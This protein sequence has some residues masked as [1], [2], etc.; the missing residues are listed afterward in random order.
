MIFNSPKNTLEISEINNLENDNLVTID[1]SEESVV[2]IV[3]IKTYKTTE[4]K[5][6]VISGDIDDI[7]NII[8]TKN[9]GYHLKFKGNENVLLFGDVDKIPDTQP[10]IIENILIALGKFYSIKPDDISLTLSKKLDKNELSYH[11]SFTGYY[12]NMKKLKVYMEMFIKQYPEFKNYIDISVYKKGLFRLPN[13]TVNQGETQKL[14]KHE[15]VKGDI[16]DF[17][18][19]NITELNELMPDIIIEKP[20][21]KIKEEIKFKI[22]K[23]KEEFII[24]LL[25]ILDDCRCDNFEE[26]RNTGFILHHELKDDGFEIF[27][28]FSSNSKKYNKADVKKWWDTIKDNNNKLT[29]GTLRK[30]AKDDD[31]ISY[32]EILNEF[33]VNDENSLDDKNK[34][35]YEEIKFEFEKN[36]FKVV[37]PIMFVTIGE[38]NELIKRSKGDFKDVYQNLSCLKWNARKDRLEKVSFINEWLEDAAMR[39]YY[40]LDFLPMQKAPNNVYNTF[41]GYEV[42]KKEIIKSDIEN[43]L[44]MKHIKNLCDNNNDVYDYVINVLARKLQQPH[45][46]T[47]T[48]LIFKSKEGAGKDLFFNWFGNKILGSEYYLNTDKPELLF[49]RFTTCLENKILVILNETNGKDTFQINE[50]IK[51]AI[52]AETNIIEHKG[53]KPYKNTNHISYNFLTNN[54]QPI[55]VPIDDRRFCGIECNNEICNNLEYFTPLRQEIN[56]GEYDKAIYNYLMSIDCSDYDF[57]NNRPKTNYY[58]DMQE[59]NIPPLINFLEDLILNSKENILEISSNSLF[60]RYNEYITNYNFKNLIKLTKFVMDIK[61]IDGVEQKRTKKGRFIV[62]YIDKLKLYLKEKYNI[63][64]VDSEFIDDEDEDDDN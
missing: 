45:I 54:D 35:N 32:K 62:L 26:W 53:L 44:I 42:E 2:N 28:N 50:N 7:T 60:L 6:K 15:I 18:V 52:T 58:N 27:D 13:Q 47:N 22:G 59:M 63:E 48:A 4:D 29:I 16:D 12:T 33:L 61:K 40:K 57:T 37:N 41:K 24:K 20:V 11:W 36:N 1:E 9:K 8:S 56:S 55:K 43:S 38:D 46:L 19:N 5:I 25:E 14:Y 31:S 34:V 64:F 49:G 39:T 10:E 23:T 30:M 3:S 21:E 17:I 51:C